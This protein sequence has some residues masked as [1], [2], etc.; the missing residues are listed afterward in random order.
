M[1]SS[2]LDRWPRRTRMVGGPLDG[3]SQP[4]PIPAGY[5]DPPFRCHRRGGGEWAHYV[6][7]DDDGSYVYGGPCTEASHGGYPLPHDHQCCC[8]RAGC[9]G[10]GPWPT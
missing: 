9:D 4:L 7:T 1:T 5:P 6:R 2:F 8:G 3:T 10:A